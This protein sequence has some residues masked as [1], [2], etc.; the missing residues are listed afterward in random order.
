MSNFVAD[1]YPNS[2]NPAP[3]ESSRGDLSIGAGFIKIGSILIKKIGP[4][5]LS[6]E[7]DPRLI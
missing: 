6:A 1:I 3:I 2:T 4:Q 5:H 7:V